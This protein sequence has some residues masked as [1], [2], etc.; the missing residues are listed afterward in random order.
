MSNLLAEDP[1]VR[2]FLRYA[3][4]TLAYR[5]GKAVRGTP[6]AFATLR[7]T[8]GSPSPQAILAHMADLMDWKLRL[9]KGTPSWTQ[10]APLRWDQEIAR[11]FAAVKALDDYLA[12]G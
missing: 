5:P 10:A 9:A 8:S 2:Q 6:E 3:L 1:A 4:A 12:S 7:A 11:F